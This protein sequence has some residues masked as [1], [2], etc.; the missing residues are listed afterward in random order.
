[1]SIVHAT[2]MGPL[3]KLLDSNLAFYQLEKMKEREEDV[4]D[5]RYNALET[6]FS[7]FLTGILEILKTYGTL[8]YIFNI[9]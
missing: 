8:Q 4:P 5:F 3:N 9:P 2:A 6:E 7:K 1:M